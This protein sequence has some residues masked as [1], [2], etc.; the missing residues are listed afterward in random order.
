MLRPLPFSRR[1]AA[2][3]AFLLTI[4]LTFIMSPSPSAPPALAG[5]TPIE[6]AAT[7]PTGFAETTIASGMSSPTAMAFAPDGR[8]FVAEQT[9]ALRVIKNGALLSTPFVTLSVNSSGERGLLG[10]AFDPQFTTNNYV[11]LYYTT[12]TSPLRNRISRFTANGDVAVGGSELQILNLDTLI[13][14]HQPQRRRHPLR[15]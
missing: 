7:L 10:I 14:R 4:A 12:S 5:E 9:G 6:S 2:F 1:L 8:L 11:Y 15:S 13:E 3:T